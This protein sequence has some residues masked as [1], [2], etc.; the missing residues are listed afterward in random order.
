MG[1]IN[2]YTSFIDIKKTIKTSSVGLYTGGTSVVK[3]NSVFIPANTFSTNEVLNI[4]AMTQKENTLNTPTLRFYWNTSDTLSSAILLASAD[5]NSSWQ[6]L[7][8]YRRIA[9]RTA[10][11]TGQGS[12]IADPSS[13][14]ASDYTSFNSFSIVSINWTVDSYILLGA[15]TSAGITNLR[16]IT[17]KIGN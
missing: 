7:S 2:G 3:L 4:E 14:F 11:G 6:S 5:Y 9:I 17:L 13:L 8:F 16:S 15:S 12:L 10:N 1:K